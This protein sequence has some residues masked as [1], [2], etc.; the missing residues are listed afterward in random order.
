MSSPESDLRQ[1]AE[2]IQHIRVAMMTTFPTRP[3]QPFCHTRPMYT[4]RIDPGTFNGELLFVTDDHTG[5]VREIANEDRVQIT[6]ADSSHNRFVSVLG[7]AMTERN[8]TKVRELWSYLL[9]AWWPAGPDDPSIAIIRVRIEF[10]E[11]WD[12]PSNGL[13]TL[14]ILRSLVTGE[15]LADAMRAESA[16]TSRPNHRTV[17]I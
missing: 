13:F 7:R 2:L 1:L 5:K 14:R 12:G 4:Q 6:Y 16:D 3:T 10:A 11:F 15:P 17:I 9:K 8:P